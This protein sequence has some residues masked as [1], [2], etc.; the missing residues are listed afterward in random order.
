M[1]KV[2]LKAPLL[3]LLALTMIACS[4][5]AETTE[6]VDTAEAS[7]T[8][9]SDQLYVQ[10]SA[11]GG[12]DY[13]YDHRMGLEEAGKAFG[14]RTEYVGPTEYDINGM[15]A[16]FEQ[17]IAKRPE[18]IIV[19]GFESSLDPIV[20]NAVAQG[21]PV[22]TVDADL[23]TSDRLAFV[24]TGNY[25]AGVRGGEKLAEL[26]GGE[27]QVALMTRAAQSNL[28]ERIQGY[29]DALAEFDGIE[30]VQIVD[31]QS[32]PVVAA[33][34][35]TA[36]L[37]RFPNLAGIAC[38]EAAGGSGAATAVREANRVGDIVIIAMD[39]G[40]EV[41]R[42]IEGGV[43]QASVAQQT[44][45]MPFY[46]LSILYQYS[47]H[48][49]PISTNNQGAGITGIPTVVDT[50]VIIVDESNYEYFLRD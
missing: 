18:G 34:A 44:A 4:N 36:L 33:S 22:V 7:G 17:S 6:D 19:V 27:G 42:A 9:T 28:E 23:P 41:L 40:N 29:R 49:V 32:D 38:V 43:I 50:G 21:I 48:P 39:R 46:A 14:V 45:L 15:V 47:N 30:I 11:L 26:I 8:D 3:V 35:A 37:Q 31:T 12:L 24:G 2:L 10:V 5:D 13:F 20:N 16:A 25:N 1:K